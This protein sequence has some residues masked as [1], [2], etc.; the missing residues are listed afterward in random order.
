MI[1]RASPMRGLGYQLLGN[2][3]RC[4]REEGL[5]ASLAAGRR[6]LRPP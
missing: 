3:F 4:H 6:V 5:I 1:L 2:T